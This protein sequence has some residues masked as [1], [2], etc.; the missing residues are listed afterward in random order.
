MEALSSQISVNSLNACMPLCLN[1]SRKYS[2]QDQDFSSLLLLLSILNP[3][4]NLKLIYVISCSN[5]LLQCVLRINYTFERDRNN[6]DI[7][8]IKK[9]KGRTCKFL[10]FS[11]D[12]RTSSTQCDTQRWSKSAYFHVLSPWPSASVDLNIC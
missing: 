6:F 8:G 4:S 12:I 10:I 2:V 5:F 1:Q 9:G 7:N 11:Y 3:F